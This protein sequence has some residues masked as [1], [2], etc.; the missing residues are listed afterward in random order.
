M[1]GVG[2]W[3][4]LEHLATGRTVRGVEGVEG[5]GISVAQDEG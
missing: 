1:V 4:F 5:R 3:C 2:C